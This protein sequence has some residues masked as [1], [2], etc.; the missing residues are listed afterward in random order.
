MYLLE[1]FSG[2]HSVKKAMK[3]KYNIISLDMNLYKNIEPP[4]HNINI[5]DFDYKQY[6][7]KLFD[8]I[9]ASPPCIN[10]SNLQYCWIGRMKKGELFTKEKMN[11]NILESDKIVKKVLEI[12]DYFK[13][14]LWFIEN[15]KNGQL[16]KREFMKDLN[17]YDVDYCMYSDFGY[18]KSTRIWTNRK[19]FINLLCNKRCGNIDETGKKHKKRTGDGGKLRNYRIPEKLIKSLIK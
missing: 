4:T 17:Y 18:Q 16:K 1:L 10:Y 3:N 13:P 9:W 6:D 8:V 12:I 2:T 7:K 15:P 11:E 19:D 5:L 14:R